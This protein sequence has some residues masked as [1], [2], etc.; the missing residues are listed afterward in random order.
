MSA[1]NPTIVAR[2]EKAA[3]ILNINPEEVLEMLKDIGIDNSDFGLKILNAGTTNE[4]DICAVLIKDVK[5]GNLCLREKAAAAIL[6]GRDPFAV[7]EKKA[8]SKSE[9]TNSVVETL[10]KT[11]QGNRPIQQWKDRELLETY[12]TDRDPEMEQELHRR[13]KA[14]PFIILKENGTTNPGDEPIDIEESLDLLKAARRG[15]KNPTIY[16]VG[17]VVKNVFMVTELNMDDRITELCPL[18]NEALYRGYCA[19][20]ELKFSGMDDDT[21]AY[22][23]LV[24]E[25]E[26]FNLNSF[27]DRRAVWASAVKGLD[28]LRMTWP[29]LSKK[30]DELK[31]TNELPRLRIIQNLPRSQKADPFYLDGNRS[32]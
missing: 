32:Y 14:Q 25:S 16:P 8:E 11:I 1:P 21:R 2:A 22:L 3:E 23:R 13:A 4:G 18:C 19:H 20:C 24:S 17:E 9:S 30:F 6:K 10:V 12:D 7:E 31:L 26:K 15:R 5:E 28:D 29:G 27:S